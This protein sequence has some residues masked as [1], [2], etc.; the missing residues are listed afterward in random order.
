MP[1]KFLISVLVILLLSSG[2]FAGIGQVQGFSIG[3][4]NMVKRV[5]GP[6]S[7][8]S[9]NIAIVGHKQKAGS[10][11]CGSVAMQK[12]VGILGQYASVDGRGG[13]SFVLQGATV[14]GLQ[15]QLVVGRGP[16]AQGQS[17]NMSLGQL[18]VKNGG[19]G[20]AIGVQGFVGYQTQR[21]DTPRT[22]STQSQFVG[23]VQYSN[24]SGSPSSNIV[25]GSI[26]DINMGQGQTVR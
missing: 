6:G 19:V 13:K 2:A 26:L 18:T 25:V 16:K 4:V 17:L 8:E 14:Q 23:A 10:F 11:C 22:K 7:A 3:A 20:G 24:I 1:K 12:E 15:G 5:G 9:L 21:I